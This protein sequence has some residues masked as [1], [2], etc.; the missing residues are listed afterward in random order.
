MNDRCT[1]L[2]IPLRQR[3][4]NNFEN[5]CQGSNTELVERLQTLASGPGDSGIWLWGPQGRGRSHLLQATCQVAEAAG[6]RAVYLPLG[7]LPMDPAIIEGLEVDLIALDDVDCWLGDHRLESQLMALYQNQLATH[8]SL[9]VVASASA[10]RQTF[11][12]PD[13]GSRLRALQ[14]FEVLAPD[15]D[16]LKIILAQLARRQGLEL[17]EAVLDFWLHRSTRA[18]PELIR[19]LDRLDARAMT[20]QRR[21]TI[22]LIKEVLAL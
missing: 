1:Q 10:Q 20:E 16:G 17:G 21:V 19:Q 7:S 2:T 22:P 6:H 5:F 13:L 14:G 3:E 4:L 8:S 9:V 11:V 12:L 15:D 18:L